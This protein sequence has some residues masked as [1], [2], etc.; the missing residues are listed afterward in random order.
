MRYEISEKAQQ[1]LFNIESY[2]LEKWTVD[3]LEDFFENFK[4]QLTF[5]WK[6]KFFFKN[7][8]IKISINSY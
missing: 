2:L 8:R 4:K 5:Y 7:M 6:R 1:D 3:V